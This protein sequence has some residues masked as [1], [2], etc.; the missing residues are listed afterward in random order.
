MAAREFTV[1]LRNATPYRMVE[2]RENVRG[3]WSS[4]GAP[5]NIIEPG[6][7]A[8]WHTESNQFAMGTGGSLWYQIEDKEGTFSGPEYIG[9]LPVSRP[10]TE[11]CIL[12]YWHNPYL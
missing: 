10:G 8:T 12:I 3:T 1:S 5:P 9:G 7:L 6:G 2:I 4:D 11:G